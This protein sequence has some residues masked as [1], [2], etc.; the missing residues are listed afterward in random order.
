[1]T[2]RGTADLYTG[3]H[4]QLEAIPNPAIPPLSSVVATVVVIPFCK[5]IVQPVPL[6]NARASEGEEI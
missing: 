1:M 6:E 4:Q 3:G 2:I 5:H